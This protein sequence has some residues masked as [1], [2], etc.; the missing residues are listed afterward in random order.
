[1][2]YREEPFISKCY[3]LLT[4]LILNSSEKSYIAAGAKIIAR[5]EK[6]TKLIWKES[7]ILPELSPLQALSEIGIGN[8][9][10]SSKHAIEMIFCFFLRNY[11]RPALLKDQKISNVTNIVHPNMAVYK[12]THTS[13]LDILRPLFSN[14]LY[15]Q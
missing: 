9:K 13:I 8:F 4:Y 11:K 3:L 5:K 7:S 10:R 1:M 12:H 6:S 15:R 14:T 2:S